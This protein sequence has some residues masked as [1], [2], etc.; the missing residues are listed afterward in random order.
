MSAEDRVDPEHL[1]GTGEIAEMAGVR[2]NVI[3]NWASRHKDFPQPVVVLQCGRIWDRRDVE[4]WLAIA[5]EPVTV[6]AIK[7]RAS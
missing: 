4:A 3:V 1:V 6:R 2:K 5:T 7:R